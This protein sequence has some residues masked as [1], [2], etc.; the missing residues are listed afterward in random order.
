[1][2]GGGR[3]SLRVAAK[4]E[5]I[6]LPTTHYPLPT[7][8]YPLPTIRRLL[9]TV[10]CLLLL[11]A[12]CPKPERRRQT[13]RAAAGGRQAAA[14]VVDDPAL[15]AAVGRMR[16]EWNAQTGA[17]LQVEQRTEKELAGADSLPADAV[18]C[19]SHL[20]GRWPSGSCW[21][22]CPARF[23]KATTGAT[24]S[25]CSSCARRPGGSR[26]WACRSAR[27]CSA[28]TIAP[29]CCESSAAAR[30]KPGPNIRSWPSCWRPP[31]PERGR[32]RGLGAAR[33]SRWRPAGPDWS[34]WPAR[35][36]TPNTATTT[37]RCSTST[38][39]SRW[40]PGRRSSRRWKNWSPRPSSGRP[41]RCRTIR[42]RLGQRSGGANAAW[43]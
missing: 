39:W 42:P 38:R 4:R 7:I 13:G 30:R 36:P 43:R 25:S 37:R 14:A 26:S 8:H 11:L 3:R 1:M 6:P 12:G 16:G 41:I 22:A 2:V 24:S 40:W 28:A 35:P 33:S 32:R 18:L 21:Q 5:T 34:C 17:E 19:P 29:T 27:R 31:S 23:C 15:A 20:L 9:P 10:Y